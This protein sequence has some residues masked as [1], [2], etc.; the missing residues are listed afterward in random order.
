VSWDC[1]RHTSSRERG[2]WRRLGG[3]DDRRLGAGR[4][5]SGITIIHLVKMAKI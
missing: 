3:P 4:A 2:H 5:R 1:H